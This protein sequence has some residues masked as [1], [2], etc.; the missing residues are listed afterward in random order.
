[1]DNIFNNVYVET[2]MVYELITAMFR[3]QNYEQLMPKETKLK[4]KVSE[5][6]GSWIHYVR[7]SMSEE[8]KK[9]LD[10]FFNIDSFFGLS[11]NS[12]IWKYRM[13][14]DV[15]E[16]IDFF[17]KEVTAKEMVMKFMETGYHDEEIDTKFIENIQSLDEAMEIIKKGSLQEQEKWKLFYLYSDAENTKKRFL[18]LISAFYEQFFVKKM[19][20]IRKFQQDSL[21]NIKQSLENDDFQKIEKILSIKYDYVKDIKEIILVPSYFYSTTTSISCS[22][23]NILLAIFGMD[24][25]DSD[26]QQEE[27]A[28]IIEAL[29]CISDEKRIKII[30]LLNQNDYYGY[31]IAQKLNL[32]NSTT[33]HHLSLLMKYRI[34][35][36]IRE[37]NKIYYEV[38]NNRINEILTRFEKLLTK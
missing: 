25:L 30:Q 12:S 7:S 28:E 10:I 3:V 23:D 36:S 27:K 9:E 18:K 29:K 31:E 15:H 20:D 37:D 8:M 35:N 5:K 32:A 2:S 34:I 38:D 24:L 26:L 17:S 22:D 1:M 16:F 4:D 13:H 33:S 14:K 11:L 6:H 21:R 19:E